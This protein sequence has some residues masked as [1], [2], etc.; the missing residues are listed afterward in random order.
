MQLNLNRKLWE[1]MLQHVSSGSPLE[2]CGLLAGK[3]GLVE[4]VIPIANQSQS[5]VR[6]RMDPVEQLKAFNR[7]EAAG[8]DL[9]GIYHSHPSGQATLSATDIAEA[10]YPVVQVVWSRSVPQTSEAGLHP[11]GDWQARGFWIES[12]NLTEVTLQIIENE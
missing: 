4:E 7:I 1:T 5:Q 10:A 12:G 6:F 2:A 11:E 3:E 9:L 8:L